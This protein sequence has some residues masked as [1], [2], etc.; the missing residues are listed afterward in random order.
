MN[1]WKTKSL[2]D[3]AITI[4]TIRNLLTTIKTQGGDIECRL[5]LNVERR[6]LLAGISVK[7]ARFIYAIPVQVTGSGLTLALC[8]EKPNT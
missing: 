1:S 6:N 8:A 4:A 7:S 3:Y 5:V 2:E